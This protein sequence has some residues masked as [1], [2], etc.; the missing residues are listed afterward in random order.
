[1]KCAVENLG[2]NTWHFLAAVYYVAKQFG[3][4]DDIEKGINDYYP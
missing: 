2:N 1:L 3:A 4:E